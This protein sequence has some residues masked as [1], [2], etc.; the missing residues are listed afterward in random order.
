MR[1]SYEGFANHIS[2]AAREAN[3]TWPIFRIPDFELHAGQVRLQTGTEAIG[4]SILVESK[5][6]DK[7]L[8]FVTANYESNVVEGHMTRYGNLE[9][10]A[11]IG[12]TPNFTIFTADAIVPDVV[13][14]PLRSASWHISPRM[15]LKID[16]GYISWNNSDAL[17]FSFLCTHHCKPC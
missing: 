15:L 13:D 14:R 7:Y 10:L 6:A 5:D 4:C 16:A 12:Y 8:E 1:Q 11:P 9:R 2:S 17:H 3:A